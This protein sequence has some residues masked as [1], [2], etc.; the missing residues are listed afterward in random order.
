MGMMKNYLLTLQ[1]NCSDQLFGQEAIEHA[2]Y[3]GAFQPTYDLQKDI[4]AIVGERGKPETGRY[5]EFCAAYRAH[6]RENE[7]VLVESYA[8]AGLLE[9]ILRPQPTYI[10]EQHLSHQRQPVGR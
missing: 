6:S 1:E 10:H 9:E 7:A 2:I 4:V 3:S 8:H 5:D